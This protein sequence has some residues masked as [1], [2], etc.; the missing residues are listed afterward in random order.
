ME[1]IRKPFSAVQL[2]KNIFYSSAINILLRQITPWYPQEIIISIIGRHG[3]CGFDL[4]QSLHELVSVV[5]Q[6][7]KLE[8]K[9]G[10]TAAE[11]KE[12]CENITDG[13]QLVVLKY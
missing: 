10:L 2:K 11:L 3:G 1:Q 9:S 7:K 5:S 8:A 6:K 13:Q 12:I 4:A